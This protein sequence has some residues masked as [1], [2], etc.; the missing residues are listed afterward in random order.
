MWS[1]RSQSIDGFVLYYNAHV[2]KW[3]FGYLFDGINPGMVC[4]TALSLGSGMVG[5]LEYE[6]TFL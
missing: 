1:T 3:K 6:P 4:N 5:L 2:N